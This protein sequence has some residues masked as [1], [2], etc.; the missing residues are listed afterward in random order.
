MRLFRVSDKE[1]HSSAAN[2]LIRFS[3]KLTD[4]SII[5]KL[6]LKVLSMK[7][8]RLLALIAT[9]IETVIEK[10]K[11]SDE[12]SEECISVLLSVR[13]A[14]TAKIHAV[15]SK[16]ISKILIQSSSSFIIDKINNSELLQGNTLP[17]IRANLSIINYLLI[18]N[19]KE[20]ATQL[21][22]KAISLSKDYSD[23]TDSDVRTAYGKLLISIS[24]ISGKSFTKL[25]QPILESMNGSDPE[26]IVGIIQDMARLKEIK[27]AN[28]QNEQKLLLQKLIELYRSVYPAIQSAAAATSFDLFLLE[29]LS[30]SDLKSLADITESPETTMRDFK[31]IITLIQSDREKL[32][33]IRS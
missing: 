16:T 17:E 33:I 32:K 28:F 25:I 18:S 21:L 30:P 11:L 8:V 6:F 24:L 27:L 29:E 20:I 31:Q 23:N 2:A 19:N 3:S 13:K 4:K 9:S 14:Q 15:F 5:I 7:N 12:I 22:P 10:I 26:S 1:I